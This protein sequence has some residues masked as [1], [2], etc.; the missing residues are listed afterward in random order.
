MNIV[1]NTAQ[2]IQD[3]IRTLIKEG[4]LNEGD[5]LPS[6]RELAEQLGVNRNTV[7]AAYKNLV[8]MG[9]VVSKGRLGTQIKPNQTSR[10]LEGFHPLLQGSI[11]LAHGNPKRELLPSLTQ[12]NLPQTT[13]QFTYWIAKC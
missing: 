10:I 6:V 7:A 9:I 12:I 4:Q 1:G 5:F 2:D 13:Q 11:D 3:N 8:A